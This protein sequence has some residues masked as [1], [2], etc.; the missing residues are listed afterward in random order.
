MLYAAATVLR[1]QWSVI[2]IT[3][4]PEDKDRSPR[5]S[6]EWARDQIATYGRDNPWIK[7]IILGEFPPSSVNTLI[8]TDVIEDALGLHLRESVYSF[9]QKRLGVDIAR[10][11]D[12]R[13]VLAPRQGLAAFTMAEMRNAN[14]PEV[15]ARIALASSR[16]EQE[17]TFIDDTGG[18]G[19]STQDSL[20]QSSI[21]FVPINFSGKADDPRYL[22][23]R[24]EMWFRMADWLKRGGALPDDPQLARELAT[25]KYYFHKG[26]FQLEEKDQI[27]K[28][29]GFSPD[30]ADALALTFAHAE[31][32]AS[33]IH[34]VEV[35]RRKHVADWDPH[36]PARA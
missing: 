29:L 4:D 13:T 31:M 30:K 19:A 1:H 6:L 18:W 7:A 12:D 5:I 2:R 32:P 25:P 23:K 27:K 3:G 15:A 11:G 14:G 17:T 9:S 34:G 22:N 35:D 8:G 16:W 21:P 24:A 26:K 28:R 33:K 10:Q 36:D 20:I